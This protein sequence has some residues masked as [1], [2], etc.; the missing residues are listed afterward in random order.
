MAMQPVARSRCPTKG[1]L[2]R[3]QTV[4][5]F[6][7]SST[8][9]I[10]RPLGGC[11][12]ASLAAVEPFDFVS[13]MDMMPTSAPTLARRE[14]KIPTRGAG[15]TW[16]TSTSSTTP[17]MLHLT[18]TTFGVSE[19]TTIAERHASLLAGRASTTSFA[20]NRRSFSDVAGQK[21]TKT[22][23][24]A[25]RICSCPRH[26]SW[27]SV[28]TGTRDKSEC[29]SRSAFWS[30]TARAKRSPRARLR[31]APLIRSWF[32]FTIS[33]APDI[34]TI[35]SSFRVSSSMRSALISK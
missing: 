15:R 14:P 25:S 9:L 31:G 23:M 10:P 32:C 16:T 13:K 21:K 18:R 24:S 28:V 8:A 19:S 33:E 27:N 3:R 12:V 35:W 26:W 17:S 6:T 22:D 29:S 2:S 11:M 1:F 7:A 34:C 30:T 4:F 20:A 5:D